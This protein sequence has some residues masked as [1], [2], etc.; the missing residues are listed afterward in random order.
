M[1]ANGDR[2]EIDPVPTWKTG[3]PVFHVAHF[4]LGFKWE[5]EGRGIGWPVQGFMFCKCETN[6]V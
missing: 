3:S 6:F 4:I 1:E 5:E 2:L